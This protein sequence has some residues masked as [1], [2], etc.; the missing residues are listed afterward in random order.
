MSRQ[1]RKAI[2]KAYRRVYNIVEGNSLTAK[3]D[4]IINHAA[5][6]ICRWQGYF[7]GETNDTDTVNKREMD[8]KAV[9]CV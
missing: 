5:V 6:D 9:R 8:K 1:S 2:E 3:D 4:A 7:P